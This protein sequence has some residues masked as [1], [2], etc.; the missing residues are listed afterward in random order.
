M[1]SKDDQYNK[2]RKKL[3]WRKACTARQGRTVWK[4][5]GG[6]GDSCRG[7][8]VKERKDVRAEGRQC[9]DF[10]RTMAGKLKMSETWTALAFGAA[11][12]VAADNLARTSNGS[13]LSLLGSRCKK[14]SVKSSSDHK[15]IHGTW[16]SN[17]SNCGEVG[18]HAAQRS[19]E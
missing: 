1:N 2:E 16:D 17:R 5:G 19:P 11:L 9:G 4:L 15:W 12:S 18:I 13:R 14:V 7:R 10:G 8:E 3:R 6:R